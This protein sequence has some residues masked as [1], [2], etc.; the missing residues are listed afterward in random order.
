MKRSLLLLA[1]L[2][3][4]FA[5]TAGCGGDNFSQASILIYN[6][7]KFIGK[8]LVSKDQYENIQKVGIV[9]NK[10]ASDQLPK[11]QRFSSNELAKGT[12][13]YKVGENKLLAK[14]DEKQYKVF[15]LKK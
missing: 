4:L 10:A 14:V 1:L 5:I 9:S 7:Q 3:M 8:E 11:D 13:I 2:S 12:E 6:N 15:E